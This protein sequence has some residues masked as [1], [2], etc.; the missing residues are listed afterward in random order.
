MV[1]HVSTEFKVLSTFRKL[2][3]RAGVS[4]V[5][6]EMWKGA[7]VIPS[8]PQA[9]DYILPYDSFLLRPRLILNENDGN[10]HNSD[11]SCSAAIVQISIN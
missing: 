10:I 1:L 6:L 5:V 4:K 9:S 11:Y 8:S 7:A 3:C 2:I